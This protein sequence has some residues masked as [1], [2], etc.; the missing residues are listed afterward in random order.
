MWRTWPLLYCVCSAVTVHVHYQRS[1][2]G[3]PTLPE[4][5]GDSKSS[6]PPLNCVPRITEENSGL[7]INCYPRTKKIGNLSCTCCYMSFNKVAS[8]NVQP[9]CVISILFHT[10]MNVYFFMVV[11]CWFGLCF[12]GTANMV[13]CTST[14]MSGLWTPPV[15]CL[16]HFN[17]LLCLLSRISHIE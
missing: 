1:D 9:N 14:I 13:V 16:L 15:G 3:M 11:I 17:C 8:S 4:S 5:A 7:E 12:G 2:T 6:C 10:F